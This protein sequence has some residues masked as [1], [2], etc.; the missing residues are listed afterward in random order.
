MRCCGNS[1][2]RRSLTTEASAAAIVGATRSYAAR[3]AWWQTSRDRSA[4]WRRVGRRRRFGLFGW[5]YRFLDG[6]AAFGGLLRRV[7]VAE[8]LIF[9]N[10]EAKSKTEN[11]GNN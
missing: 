4:K 6:F 5:V 9:K 2:S 11:K 8:H 1:L 3:A 7:A 10:S